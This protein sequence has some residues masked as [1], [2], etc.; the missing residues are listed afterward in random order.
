[1]C[2]VLH[3]GLKI[4]HQVIIK[5]VDGFVHDCNIS[6]GNAQW[7]FLNDYFNNFINL[8][9]TFFVIFLYKSNNA[10]LNISKIMNKWLT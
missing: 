7:Y 3:N 6:I 4:K 9:S 1:M 2:I 10:L 8:T 5:T